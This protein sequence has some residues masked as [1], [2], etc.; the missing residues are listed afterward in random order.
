MYLLRKRIFALLFVGILLAFS[1]IN[2]YE[3]YPTLRR[4]VLANLQPVLD[5]EKAPAA[6]IS[7][8]ETETVEQLWQRMDFIEGYSYVQALLDKREFNNFQFVKDEEGLLHYG[9]FFREDT[10]DEM[11]YARRIRRMQDYVAPFGTKVLFV[12]PPSKYMPKYTQLR[13]EIGINDPTNMVEE[14]MFY[15]NRFG[16]ETLNLQDFLPDDD[17]DYDEIFYRTDHHWTVPAAF[18]ASR[19]IV[20]T[21]NERFG[22]N[23][24]PDNFY[25]NIENYDRVTYEDGMFGSM[26]RRTGAHF[27]GLE[28]FVSYWPRFTMHYHRETTLNGEMQTQEGVTEEALMY[29]DVLGRDSDIYSDS[30]Y[31]LYLNSLRDLEKI[32]N[33]DNPDAPS[34]LIIRDSYMSPVITFLA[35]MFGEIYAVRNLVEKDVL[36]IEEFVRNHKTDYLIVEVYPFNIT[37]SAAFAFFEGSADEASEIK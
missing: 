27:V 2:A 24:D 37:D 30:K 23:L 14:L 29:L 26:G 32:E 6:F 16:V 1:A 13:Q 18:E 17:L 11:E 5:G 33:L 7:E 8:L 19:I 10:T 34:L 28:D 12:V 35:P 21:I 25:T 15:L 4:T 36:D 20:Q 22:E 3:A 9:S 31:S